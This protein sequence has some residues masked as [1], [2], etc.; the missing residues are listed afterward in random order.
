MRMMTRYDEPHPTT[1]E[2]HRLATSEPLNAA[3][4]CL[5]TREAIG[6]GPSQ[7]GTMAA[8]DEVAC[9]AVPYNTVGR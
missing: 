6:L 4:V 1:L 8:G 5:A 2:S 7:A 3:A 9:T